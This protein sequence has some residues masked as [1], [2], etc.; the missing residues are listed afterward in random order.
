VNWKSLILGL[1]FVCASAAEAAD[2][3]SL[4]SGGLERSYIVHRPA[5]L[6]RSHFVPLV[7][8]LHGGF[9]SGSQAEAAY[10]WDEEADRQG[11][12]AVYPDGIRRAWNA[13]GICCGKPNREGVDDVGFITRLIETV[14]RDENIDK[15]RVY[16]TGISNGAAMSYRYGCEGSF[17]I[18]AIGAVAGSFSFSCMKPHAVSVMEIHGLDDRNIPFGGGKGSKGVSG[19]DWLGVENSLDVFRKAD[20]CGAPATE[21][22]GVVRKAVSHCA[23]GREVAL[24]TIAGAGHQWP[25]SNKVHG[26]AAWL[27]RLD[28]PSTAL[29]ATPVLWRFFATAD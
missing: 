8:V 15:K 24:I 26:L 10:K 22:S 25:G 14:V 17:P 19:V 13:G 27:L 4:E 3:R 20:G 2:T 9:G 11:F 7:I 18:A 23:Q 12:V 1:L 29:D 6:A 5:N 21:E 28:P 16:L